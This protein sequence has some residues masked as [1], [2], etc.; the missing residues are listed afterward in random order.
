MDW[1]EKHPELKHVVVAQYWLER[2]KYN[3]FDWDMN[4]TN[5]SDE[6]QTERLRDFCSRVK[7]LGKQVI[8]IGPTPD[9][10]IHPPRCARIQF[11][12]HRDGGT[13]TPLECSRQVYM[14]R[15]GKIIEMLKK[16]EEEGLAS[17]LDLSSVVPQGESFRAYEN[18]VLYFRD[19]NH[20]SVAGAI[21]YMTKLKGRFFE[22]ISE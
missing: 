14:E 2:M 12:K 17:L 4:K 11:A 20:L 16:M 21:M 15:H 22:L 10:T 5:Y 19:K 13:Y 7:R 1:L 9:Y 3:K 6:E 18:G 8:L